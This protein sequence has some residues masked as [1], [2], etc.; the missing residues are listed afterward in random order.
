MVYE[1]HSARGLICRILFFIILIS[2]KADD[3]PGS[4]LVGGRTLLFEENA[5]ILREAIDSPK[6]GETA[7]DLEL[8]RAD[9]FKP[10]RFSE[11]WKEKPVIL[12]FGSVTCDYACRYAPDVLRLYERFH[13]QCEFAYIYIREAHAADGW[14][15]DK[16]ISF[17]NDPTSIDE[18]TTAAVSFVD[19]GKYPFPVYLDTMT[20]KAAK[21]YYAWPT[22]IYVIEKGGTIGFASEVGPWGFR[23]MRST[24]IEESS[25]DLEFDYVPKRH[26]RLSTEAFL[27]RHLGV[28][29]VARSPM[30]GK[31]PTLQEH[32][33]N[34]IRHRIENIPAVNEPAPSFKLPM[35]GSTDGVDLKSFWADKPAVLTFGSLSSQ[36][37]VE[38]A[39][40]LEKLSREFGSDFN[41]VH[42]YN[43]E[44][45]PGK[46]PDPS[47]LETRALNAEHFK[48]ELGVSYSMLVDQMDDRASIYYSAWPSRLV[49]VGTKGR[50]LFRGFQ[51]PWAYKPSNAYEFPNPD[52]ND[53]AV[54]HLS[55]VVSLE[56]FLRQNR[57]TD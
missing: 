19:R 57:R 12:L 8:I 30:A 54:A 50:I 6:V 24:P 33:I 44:A 5:P 41:F 23:P 29:L 51:G 13:P 45:N 4:K 25:L 32:V 31:T 40:H 18:R 48:N 20:D 53:V 43:R 56:D 1:A 34:I 7:P 2:G 9:N 26:Q 22:R 42:I 15:K 10:V 39:N 36:T 14:F 38:G 3:L 35:I 28:D 55:H 21:A 49:V 47:T 11:L 37:A 52:F 17:I 16:T 27:D 46:I